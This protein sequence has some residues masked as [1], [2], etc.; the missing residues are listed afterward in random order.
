MKEATKDVKEFQEEAEDSAEA[1]VDAEG[2]EEFEKKLDDIYMKVGKIMPAIAAIAG[3]GFVAASGVKSIG[4]GFADVFKIVKG[5]TSAAIDMGVTL[6]K[7]VAGAIFG[8][9]K[10]MVGIA[11]KVIDW[12]ANLLGIN[13][14][15]GIIKGAT[16]QVYSDNKQISDQLAIMQGALA[17]ALEPII[18]RIVNLVYTLFSFINSIVKSMT[19][20]DL[21]ASAVK[22]LNKSNKSA[23]ELKK[24]LAGFDEMNVLSDNS[25]GSSGSGGVSMGTPDPAMLDFLDELKKLFVDGD[26]GKIAQIFSEKVVSALNYIADTIAKIDWAGI[27]AKVSDFLTNI[28]YSGI[29]TGLVRVFGEAVLAL[30]DFLLAIDWPKLVKKVGEAIADA[31]FKID[32]YIK[33]IKWGDIGKLIG[34][35][36]SSIPW[37]EI[38]TSIIETVWD[39]ITGLGDLLWN[40]DWGKVAESLYTGV[41]DMLVKLQLLLEGIDWT[42]VGANFGDMIMDWIESVNWAEVQINLL[43]AIGDILSAV[44]SFLMGLLA[45]LVQRII[46]KVCELFG[47]NSPST[48]FADI[49][50]YIV[51]GLINGIKSLINTVVN[52]FKGIWNSIKTIFSTVGTW[53]RDKFKEAYNKIKEVFSGIKTFFSGVWDKIKEVFSKVGTKVGDAFSKAFKGVVNTVLGFLEDIVNGAVSKINFLIKAINKVGELLHLGTIGEIKTVK[54]PRLAKGGIINYPS[55]GVPVGSA[56]AGESGRE[57]VIPLTDS[58]QM[59]LLGEAIGKYITVNASITNTMNGRVISRELQRIN[60]ESDFAFNR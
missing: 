33:K 60:N 8:I 32:E 9:G 41:N 43:V 27:G 36:I 23:K 59:A 15:M 42:L 12:G 20:K 54:I 51:E 48:V 30:Q 4:N 16:N 28:D 47:I 14:I 40:I 37:G 49:G 2:L 57:G 45:E 56:I 13:K 7:G 53:F 38:G 17:S 58:Q 46:N 10:A 26:F 25:G 24:Q 22:N 44:G 18:S 11:S 29:L 34:E 35:T 21:F 39:A 55:K 5:V 1:N 31:I 3:A 50:M 19:G 6:T 52:L